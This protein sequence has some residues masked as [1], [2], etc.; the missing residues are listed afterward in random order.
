M[1]S[2]FVKGLYKNVMKTQPTPVQ[3]TKL[4]KGA[5][6][7]LREQGALASLRDYGCEHVLAYRRLS[8]HG[9]RRNPDL[10]VCL[11]GPRRTSRSSADS[12]E[13]RGRDQDGCS[14]WKAEQKARYDSHIGSARCADK[15]AFDA[16]V[17][18]LPDDPDAIIRALM[19]ELLVG[20]I[21]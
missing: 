16:L 13:E 7:E 4:P 1:V 12:H 2:E 14:H 19:P 5:I 11:E 6:I 3:N 15:K 9:P 20:K 10:S 18:N 21:F 8:G 17:A